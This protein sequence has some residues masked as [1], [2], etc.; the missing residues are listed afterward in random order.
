MFI[1]L[2]GLLSIGDT[3]WISVKDKLPPMKFD[4]IDQ[5]ISDEVL[6]VIEGKNGN[7]YIDMGYRE[8][9]LSFEDGEG[10]D[11]W[12]WWFNGPA[13]YDA[14]KNVTHCHHKKNNAT[15]TEVIL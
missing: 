3:M 2:L 7:R 15:I 1:K 11:R 5:H 4:G 6:L 13:S 12:I 14:H 9:F 8:T 10:M